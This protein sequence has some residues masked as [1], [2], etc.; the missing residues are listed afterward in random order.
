MPSGM[1]CAMA[2][3]DSSPPPRSYSNQELQAMLGGECT[4]VTRQ[5]IALK[6]QIR[7]KTAQLETLERRLTRS[8]PA[9]ST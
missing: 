4:A 8:R 3:N 1:M 7:E 2:D 5:V 9:K 6:H